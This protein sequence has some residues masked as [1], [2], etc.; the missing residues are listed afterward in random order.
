VPDASDMSLGIPKAATREDKSAITAAQA[1]MMWKRSVR[2]TRERQFSIA[3]SIV[4]LTNTQEIVFP[5][6]AD[7]NALTAYLSPANEHLL[8]PTT[9]SDGEW[10]SCR[11]ISSA[12]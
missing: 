4:F 8:Q 11:R 7:V 1:A 9:P 3:L 10:I 6:K 12:D 2:S 5:E